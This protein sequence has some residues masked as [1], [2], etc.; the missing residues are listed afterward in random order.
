MIKNS[1]KSVSRS[2]YVINGK[3]RNKNTRTFSV[4]LSIMISRS[5][6]LGSIPSKRHLLNVLICL[7]CVITPTACHWCAY[8]MCIYI[9]LW[10]WQGDLNVKLTMWKKSCCSM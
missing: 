6:C 9:D 10:K 7:Q 3:I 8:C 5:K 1:I 2:D 4:F